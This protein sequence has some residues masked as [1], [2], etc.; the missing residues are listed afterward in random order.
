[1][2]PNCN[3]INHK[4]LFVDTN[5]FQMCHDCIRNEDSSVHS[6]QLIHGQPASMEVHSHLLQVLLQSNGM[7]SLMLLSGKLSSSLDSLN[8]SLRHLEPTT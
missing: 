2:I 4:L 5:H 8:G 7:L 6:N 3:L 1:M